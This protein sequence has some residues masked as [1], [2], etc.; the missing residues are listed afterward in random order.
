MSEQG[1]ERIPYHWLEEVLDALRQANG[2]KLEAAKL[3]GI[4]KTKMY[5]KCKFYAIKGADQ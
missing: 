2:N 1:L 5:D 4:G 3:L